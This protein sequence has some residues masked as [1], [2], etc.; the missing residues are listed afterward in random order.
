MA[1]ENQTVVQDY[2]NMTPGQW[3]MR[4]LHGAL[5]GVGSILPGVSG[6]VLCVLFGIYKPMMALLAHP[7]KAFKSYYKL[8]IPVG[9]GFVAGFIGLAKVVE[10]LFGENS[11]LAICLFVGLIAGT[12]PSL[13]KD[14]G[15]RGRDKKSWVAL[16]I[17]FVVIFTILAILKYSAKMTIAPSTFWYFICGVVWGLS[18]VVPGLSSSSILIFLGLYEPMAAGIGNLNFGVLIPLLIGIL[19]TALLCARFVNSLLEKHYAIFNHAIF[20]IVCASTV[21]IIPT[22]YA[23]IGEILLCIVFAVVGFL[24]AML[25][26]KWGAGV[27]EK[28][29]IT[30]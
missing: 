19:F 24:A 18:L 17:S 22:A 14:A 6:G 29:N 8:F 16:G 2:G 9:I 30:D 7:F 26:D 15:E 4:V 10:W 13:F 21:L 23:G 27:K 28:N 25:L 5:I 20:G 1:S 12:L 3:L 11:N